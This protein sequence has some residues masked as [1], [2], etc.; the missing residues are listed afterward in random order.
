MLSFR[1]GGSV[2]LADAD[3]DSFAVKEGSSFCFFLRCGSRLLFLL[4]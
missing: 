3:V 2:A 4:L 1:L